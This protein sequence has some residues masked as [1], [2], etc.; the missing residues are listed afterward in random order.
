MGGGGGP[1]QSPPARLDLR[2]QSAMGRDRLKR[3][4]APDV[5]NSSGSC[6]GGRTSGRG[7]GK[8]S[9]LGKGRAG[10]EGTVLG[11]SRGGRGEA[12]ERFQVRV[13]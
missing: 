13:S 11:G 5:S 3:L 6:W 12:A 1:Q 7:S 4:G 10:R 8:G 9:A 2:I